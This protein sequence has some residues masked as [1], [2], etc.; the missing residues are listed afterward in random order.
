VFIGQS[1]VTGVLAQDGPDG[2]L[3]MR[4]AVGACVEH[5]SMCPV[6]DQVADQ[7]GQAHL[8]GDLLAVGATAHVHPDPRLGRH[9]A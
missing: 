9:H 6:D 2:P 5:Q 4:I 3:V 1:E 8:S 7:T